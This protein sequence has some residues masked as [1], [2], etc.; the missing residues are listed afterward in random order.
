MA[1]AV[2]AAGA[3]GLVRTLRRAAGASAVVAGSPGR[4]WWWPGHPLARHRPIHPPAR[5]AATATAGGVPPYDP[6]RVEATWQE[7]WR[8]APPPAPGADARPHK[9]VLC[10]FPYPSGHLHIGHLRVYTISDVIARTERMRGH[11]VRWHAAR[12]Q[13]CVA[14]P[15]AEPLRVGQVAAGEHGRCC[16]RSVGT[17]SACPRRTRPSTAASRPAS[18]RSTTSATCAGS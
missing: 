4:P 11:R 2:G 7:R 15:Q 6:A 8:A 17:R 3:A 14:L 5:L 1:A 12:A 9:Y 18:G 13:A 10:M 16:T